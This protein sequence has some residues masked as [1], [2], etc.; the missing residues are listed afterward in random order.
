MAAVLSAGACELRHSPPMPA[1]LV[2]KIFVKIFSKLGSLVGCTAGV[3]Y[4]TYVLAE[5]VSPA[6]TCNTMDRPTRWFKAKS[7]LSHLLTWA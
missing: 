1:T 4:Q 6:I 5:S 7:V 3:L 2:A